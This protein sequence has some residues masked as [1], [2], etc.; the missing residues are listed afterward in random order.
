MS[1][2]EAMQR[3]LIRH[4]GIRYKVYDDTMGI[5]TIGVGR[6]LFS[7]GI[8]HQEAIYLL[9]N[10]IEECIQDLR[11]IFNGWHSFDD[12]IKRVLID[13]RFNL[14]PDGFRQF[15]KMI[16]AVKDKDYNKMA[17]EMKNSLWYR[18]V[19]YRGNS[20]INM[21]KGVQYEKDDGCG[22]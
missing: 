7:K 6:N 13:M 18:Q 8:S 17:A 9:N 15:R 16:Q 20:L 3:Q 10:D 12:G 4:E 5:P 22:H 1:L 2:I 21:V 11:S 14:G 19:G